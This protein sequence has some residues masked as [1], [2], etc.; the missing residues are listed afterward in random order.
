MV[1]L[2]AWLE[3]FEAPHLLGGLGAATLVAACCFIDWRLF[4]SMG[5]MLSAGYDAVYVLLP[6]CFIA[7]S[8]GVRFRRAAWAVFVVVALLVAGPMAYG[9][10]AGLPKDWA[11]QNPIAFLSPLG[12]A[13]VLSLGSFATTGARSED[14]GFGFGDWRWWGP[15]LGLAVAIIVP[16]SFLAVAVV[17]GL[18]A[19]YPSDKLA[20]ADLG[21]LFLA[22]GLKGAALFGEEL[23]WHGFALFA[24]ARSHGKRAAVLVTSFG[25]FLLHKG[26]PEMEML[27]SFPGALLLGVACLRCRS[28]WPAFLGHWPMN[29]CVDLAAFLISGPRA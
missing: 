2:R 4:P 9:K 29:F 17:P 16:F 15:K 24:I 19:Y 8:G 26:K 20:R 18:Q 13:A 10:F 22:Q 21:Q 3:E 14:W 5:R 25:Y 23:F 12:A 6:L 11:I 7:A 1:R 27:S 28:F